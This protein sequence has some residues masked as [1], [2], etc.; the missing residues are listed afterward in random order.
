MRED[1]RRDWDW[2]NRYARE[3]EAI[4]LSLAHTMVTFRWGTDEEDRRQA[5]DFFVT[6]NGGGGVAGRMRREQSTRGRRDLSLRHSRDGRIQQPYLGLGG[7]PPQP[8]IEEAKIL[9]GWARWY[10]YIWTEG[11]CITE[12]IF[13]DLDKLRRK[14][15]QLERASELRPNG[16]GTAGRY[17]S[18]SSLDLAGCLVAHHHP[19][20]ELWPTSPARGSR[21]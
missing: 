1:V 13:V 11:D 8:G 7:P 6:V 2:S 15:H 10:L 17:I 14:W 20:M 16:D 18:I 19:Q 12:W 4:L 9:D 3:I 21:S 5:T